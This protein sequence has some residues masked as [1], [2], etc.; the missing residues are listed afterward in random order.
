MAE[1]KLGRIRFVWK[2]TWN[3]STTYYR[4]DVVRYGGKTYICIA[5]HT[6]NS[7]FYTDLA[8]S[9]WNLTTDGQ[10]FKGDWSTATYYKVSDIVRYGSLV[11]ICNTGHT[12][13][14]YLEDDQAKWNIFATAS[15]D[16]KSDWTTSTY[17]KIGDTV[18]YGA[19]VYR[20]NTSHISAATNALGLENDLVKWD[21]VTQSFDYK[22]TWSNAT[23][24]YKKNDV[25]KY[26]GGLWLCLNYHTSDTGRT[27]AADETSNYWIQ[28]VEGLEFED[29]WNSA[30]IYQPGDVVTYGGYQYVSTS[31]HSNSTPTALTDW[32]LFSTGF[33]FVGD[34]TDATGYK[35]GDVVRLNGYTYLCTGDHTSASVNAPPDNTYWER[36]NYGYEWQGDWTDATAY[37]LGDTVKYNNFTYVCVQT[38]TSAAGTNRPDVDVSGTYWNLLTGGVE[39]TA[40]TTQGDIVYYSGSGPARLPIGKDGQILK[41][42]N[43]NLSWDTWGT[44]DG[45]YYVSTNGTDAL[46]Y[47]YTLDKPFKTVRYATERVLAGH[48][49]LNAKTLLELNRS[50]IQAEIVEWTDYQIANSI[51]PFTGAFTYDKEKCRRD[52]GLIVDAVAWDLSHGGNVRSREAALAYF[53]E[54]GASYISG[55]ET[56]TVASITYGLA[57]IDAVLSNTAPAANYQT[58][59]AVGSPITQQ[60]NSAYDEEPEAQGIVNGLVAVVTDSITTGTLAGIPTKITPQDTVFVK[61]GE[62]NEVLPII[63]PENCAIVGDELRSTRIQPAGSLVDSADTPYSLD[64][65]TRL[66]AIISDIVQ[67]NSV[68]KTT[69]GSA[70]NTETQVTTRPAGSSG[71]AAV[72]QNLVTQIYDY[73]DWSVNGAT[74]D[75]TVP[76]TAGS[77]TPESSTGYTYAVEA[78][79]ANR[80]FIK[81]EILAYIAATYPSYTYDTASCSRDVDRYLDAIKYDLIYTGNYKS[82]LAARYY[83]N[84]VNGSTQEDMFYLR[85]GTGLRN[86]TV[87]GLTGTLGSANIYGT[88]RPSAGAFVSLDPGWGVNDESVWIRTRSPY[89][90]NV[91]TFGT[92]A[93]GLKVDGDLHAG[94]NDSI[95]ANDFTQVISDGIGAWV[96]NLG[97]AELVSVFSYY[98]HIGY[99][100]ENGGKIRATNGNSSYGTFGCVAEGVDATETPITATVNNRY[101]DAEIGNVFTNGNQILRLEYKNAGTA[102]T[103]ENNDF[104]FTGNG[105]GETVIGDEIRDGAVFEAR[106]L[107]SGE[108]YGYPTGI[109]QTGNTTTITLSG[110]DTGIST[111][112]LGMRLVITAGKGVGQYGYIQAY[113]A[114]TKLATIYKES[115]DTPGWDHVVP[116]TTTETILDLTT[117]Y[118]IEPR[119]EFTA[120]TF[121]AS[122]AGSLPSSA[123]W[124]ASSFGDGYFVAVATGS[125]STTVSNDGIAWTTGGALPTSTTWTA[126]AS[127][128]VSTTTYH[129]AVASGGTAAAYSLDNGTTW[130]AGTLT[131]SAGWS[132]IAYGSG[133]FVAVAS[134]STST[135]YSTNGGATWIA[136]G[137]LPSSTTWSGIAY[138]KNKFVAISGGASASTAAAYSTNGTTWIATT[139]PASANW[140]SV[141]YGNGSFIAIAQGSDQAAISTDGITWVS[142]T[143]PSSSS[144]K[145]VRYGQG[146]FLAVTGYGGS[147]S[148]V[149]ASSVDGVNWTARTLTSAAWSTLAFG[150]PNSTPIWAVLSTGALTAASIPNFT[151]AKARAVIASGQL[152]AIHFWEPGSGY[153]SA[154]TMTLTDPSNSTDATWTIR[155]GNGA[156]G[157]PSIANGGVGYSATGAF[158]TGDGYRDQY[159]TGF[160]VNLE[161]ITSVPLAGSNV[162]FD[163]DTQVYKLVT[164]TELLGTGPYTARLQIS[165]EMTISAAPEHATPVTIRIRYSQVRLTGHDFLDIGT[166]NFTNTNYPNTPLIP[167][168]QEAETKE[169]GGGRVFFT[170]TDQDGNFRVGDL[171]S[172]EQSTG[173][174]TLN[175]NAFNLSGLNELQLGS[176][177]LGS[178]NTAINEFSTDGTFAANSDSIV[179]TQRAIRT[180]I[181][182]QI[183]G[184]G[185][186]LNVNTLVAGDVE[187]SSNQ[188]TTTSG[189]PININ[190]KAVFNAGVDGSP[191]ALNFFL[192]GN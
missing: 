12:S 189:G 22:G 40:M 82:L 159:Q 49:Y 137:A 45:V 33:K 181:E 106:L 108:D 174:S 183:G 192:A 5:G 156:L 77:N 9:K 128:K 161:G 24:R 169:Y 60:I 32:D 131:A 127:G 18:R 177:T 30:T 134:G 141:T 34:Y 187:I 171:F 48:R 41:V 61:T 147:A 115:T 7:D 97:R 52:M 98:A 151:P 37:Q 158:M 175:A 64:A 27:F 107:T 122:S 72:A 123:N 149:A 154:P 14:T 57:V 166:G 165:P 89:V 184:G 62:F 121:S 46:D 117:V 130:S 94:G 66:E 58:L 114:G 20:A 44:V 78:L 105:Y 168:D 125:T 90:Q 67:N 176:V 99:L 103:T 84:A 19:T 132:G 157:N 79:E 25:V 26:G 92:A 21:I 55:Q 155:T 75:S 111:Q 59:N 135:S 70:P 133:R 13:Q 8:A 102:Y 23:V 152:A 36:L 69:T 28:F 1:F 43:N 116:G 65:L 179:P 83:V 145:E 140:T 190:K 110:A 113:N 101:F 87:Q 126:L 10:E 150:N 109:A 160:Y 38:H 153:T 74:G 31:N 173:R 51:A 50:F 139:L 167:A 185:A 182:S 80:T 71:A 148:T 164:V 11:Y 6:S 29:T 95:V 88:K 47:G 56:E 81:A 42:T 53:T 180:Y 129:V 188:I 170:S 2:N 191:L 16:W 172:V 15:F 54:L 120:P 39:T 91:T 143:M 73:I 35:V 186:I 85:N 138:G 104:T 119:V 96:T 86:C 162:V 4:D 136:G 112:Y 68:S 93:I 178:S 17:Y 63:V 118:Q 100:A 76:L 144:W 3:S 142:T 146:T 163:G 124:V